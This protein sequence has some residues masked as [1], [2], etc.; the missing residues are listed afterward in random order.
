MGIRFRRPEE[1]TLRWLQLAPTGAMEGLS[2]LIAFCVAM[3]LGAYIAGMIP[4]SCTMH[5]SK[6]RLV[7]IFGAGLL[8]GTAL[9]VIIPEGV[10]MHYNAQL[11]KHEASLLSGVSPAGAPAALLHE[12]HS[13]HSHRR[14]LS[15]GDASDSVASALRGAVAALESGVASVAGHSFTVARSLAGKTKPVGAA[16]A[17]AAAAAASSPAGRAVAAAPAEAAPAAAHPDDHDHA[18]EEE[19][20]GGHEHGHDHADGK[21]GGPSSSSP[22]ASAAESSHSSHGHG[23]NHWH[24]GAALALGFAFQLVVDRLSGPC[25]APLP[26]STSSSSSCH[27]YLHAPL[28]AASATD[29]APARRHPPLRTRQS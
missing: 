8:V 24:I 26:P 5:E 14:L 15:A 16:P 23:D 25:G 4:M 21:K 1:L 3:F 2:L 28:Q 22:S 6:L 9:I 27:L 10:A 11:H 18:E 7:T 29:T 20:A 13:G 19:G 12:A 17:T